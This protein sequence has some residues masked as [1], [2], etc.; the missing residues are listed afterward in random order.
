MEEEWRDIPGYEGY[1]QASTYGRIRS[2]DRYV[3]SK[4]IQGKMLRKGR[5]IRP[6]RVRE[7][8]RVG[9]CKN[10]K[11]KQCLVA[12][13]VVLTYPEICGVLQEGTQVNHKSEF[14]KDNNS[15]WNLE[16][17]SVKYNNNYGTRKERAS[18]SNMNCDTTSVP[19]VMLSL[20]GEYE[21][22]FQSTA[23]AARFVGKNHSHITQ[24]CQGK[25]N[26]AYGHK[27]EY[28][29]SRT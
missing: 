1:Y 14:E 20:A 13:L 12:T 7:Y 25:R 2:V 26:F 16:V 5:I 23:E 10:G 29:K 24:C 22:T 3:D 21:K 28:K 18:K 4:E 27:W 11:K 15:V 17:V 19:V 8:L 6:H 9:L